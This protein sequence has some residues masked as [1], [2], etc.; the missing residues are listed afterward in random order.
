MIITTKCAKC[1]GF[2]YDDTYIDKVS[3]KHII[4]CSKCNNSTG[5]F[6]DILAAIEEW[7][8][9]NSDTESEIYVEARS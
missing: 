4:R 8:R 6:F 2:P 9:M 7:D 5:I 1:G 3:R